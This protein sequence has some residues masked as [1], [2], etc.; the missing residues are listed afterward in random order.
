[1]YHRVVCAA[2][3]SGVVIA[4]VL[5]GAEARCQT[6]TGQMMTGSDEEVALVKQLDA[7]SA[8]DAAATN[9]EGAEGIV[10]LT[11]GFNASLVTTSQHDSNS[12][13]SSLLTP[14]IAYRFDKHFSV[15]V[16]LP[17]YMYIDVD[18]TTAAAIVKGVYVPA[19]S[20]LVTDHLLLGDTTLNGGF[21]AHAKWLDYN[22]TGTLGMP[23]GDDAHGLGA[24]QFTYAFINHFEHSFNDYLTPNIELGIDDSPNLID[25]RVQKNYTDVGTN[26][27]FQ[28]GFGF[29]FPFESYFETDA[30]E[31]LPLGEQTVTS[32][33]TN[34]KK[35]KQ[36]KLI[37][38]SSQE[39]IG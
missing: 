1:L 29:S 39:G 2:R 10:P 13:W 32:T 23:T 20:T 24:G 30:Y 16:G 6:G 34:G 15:D 27:H 18:D 9:D 5:P 14:N 4:L 25:T 8:S 31:E 11:K 26:A 3:L 37:T 35:G 12:G 36:L 7:L 19:K 22:L 17:V 28:A 38:T 33:T 21:D